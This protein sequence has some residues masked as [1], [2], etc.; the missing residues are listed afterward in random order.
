VQINIALEYVE[1]LRRMKRT[2]EAAN[3]TLCL[4]A[5]YEHSQ[6]ESRTIMLRLREVA[7]LARSFGMLTVSVSI[8]KRIW[9]WFK[10]RNEV[11][12]ETATE[13]TVLITEVVQEITETTTET[14]TTISIAESLTREVYETTLTRC[15]KTGQVD[16]TLFKAS[17]ALVTTYLNGQRWSDA[18]IVLRQSLELVWGGVLSTDGK[19]VIEGT[20]VSE[21]IT[22]VTRLASCYRHQELY[23]KAELLYNRLFQACITSLKAEDTRSVEVTNSIVAFHEEFHQHQKII[24]LYTQLLQHYRK[25]LGTKHQFTIQILKSLAATYKLLGRKEAFDCYREIVTTYTNDGRCHHEAFDAAKLLLKF[26][27]RDERWSE[28]ESLCVILWSTIQQYQKDTMITEELLQVVYE[29]Y[30]YVLEYHSKA[31]F[32]A[33][34]KTSIEYRDTARKIFGASAAVVILAIIELAEICEKNEAHYDES[35]T[36]YEEVI[37]KT[38]TVTIVK[39]TKVHTI[40]KRLSSLYVTL[41]QKGTKTDKQTLERAVGVCLEAYEQ[42]KIELSWWHETT[43]S[44]L[45]DLVVLYTKFGTK[46]SQVVITELLQT[47]VIKIMSTV[48]TATDLYRSAATLAS[49]YKA[50]SLER[51]GYDLLR[52]LQHLILFPGFDSEE[53]ISI[54][55][56]YTVKRVVY[57]F[58]VSFEEGLGHAATQLPIGCFSQT[59]ADLMMETLLYEQHVSIT[60]T[61]TETTSFEM[62]LETSA[63]LRAVWVTRGRSSFVTVLD[64][65]LFALFTS[66]YAKNLSSSGNPEAAFA[67]YAALLAELGSGA[68]SERPSVDFALA[69]CKA[70]NTRVRELMVDKKDFSRAF[71]VAECGFNFANTQRYYQNRKCAILGYHLAGLLAGHEIPNFKSADPSLTEKSLT[72]SRTILKSVLVALREGGVDFVSLRFED[73]TNLVT[74]L[75]EQKSYTELEDLLRALW[76]SREVQRGWSTDVVL[77]LGSLLVDAHELAGHTDAAITL[78]D[79][80]YYNIRQSRSRVD[81]EA[82]GFAHRLTHLLKRAGRASDASRIHAEVLRDL[83]EFQDGN[84][85]DERLRAAADVHLEGMRLCGTAVKAEGIRTA[86]ELYRRLAKY[87]NLTVPPVEQWKLAEPV[88]KNI[89]YEGPTEWTFKVDESAEKRTRKNKRDSILPAQIRWG[90]W[91][92]SSSRPEVT[93]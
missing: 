50:A 51:E 90:Y 91:T 82:L 29:Q 5:D 69:A 47:S 68:F 12:S 49:I 72:I 77:C 3:I 13:T 83:D 41:I 45:N 39:E 93:V 32:S 21:K 73:L 7:L 1:Y 75:G 54:K 35:I 27:R 66:R 76:Q 43:L 23:Q 74:L 53:K 80:L 30:R 48:T 65:K 64:K 67:F 14:S 38:K 42:L 81:T 78:C 37:T 40:K 22:T 34:Y 26:Y 71:A 16:S 44:K 58:L 18:E 88:G 70:T 31:D 87:G 36:L 6:Y 11:D 61:I 24:D 92:T 84:K 52:Q 89:P 4:L 63:R 19:I 86:R 85:R 15:K 62:V 25:H 60:K 59:L 56:D 10:A 55:F 57:V 9:S 28:L 33:L 2:E 8:L 17:L 20:F 46:K 79:T